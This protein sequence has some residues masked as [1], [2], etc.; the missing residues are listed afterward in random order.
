MG[1]SVQKP[2]KSQKNWDKSITKLLE[3][4]K[5]WDLQIPPGTLWTFLWDDAPVQ[6]SKG[7]FAMR[8]HQVL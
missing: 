7:N 5:V 2:V 4:G 1:A 8:C 6:G 3:K